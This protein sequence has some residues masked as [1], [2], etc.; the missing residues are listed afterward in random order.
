MVA[1]SLMKRP[2]DCVLSVY[3]NSETPVSSQCMS[4]TYVSHGAN[5]SYRDSGSGLPVIFLHPTPLDHAYWLPMIGELGEVRAI[6]PDLRGHGSSELGKDLPVG[7]F[8]RVPDAP[9]LSMGQ[10]AMDVLALMDHLALPEAV[11][12][13]CSIGGYVMTELWRR[14]P[15]RMRGLAI[16]CSKPQP[17]VESNFAKRAETIAQIRSAGTKGV[18][19]GNAQTLIGASARKQRPEIVAELRARM[20]LTAEAVIATQ[21]GLA[22]RP[23]SVPDIAG[24]DAPILAICGGEDPGI[25][26]AEMR[27]FEG[28]EG[29]CEFHLLADAGHFAAYEQPAKVAA[30]IAPWFGQFEF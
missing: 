30:L 11:F 21:A 12:A 9:V 18:F 27:A 16:V 1:F 23:D 14:A 19:D 15:L 10:L 5:L 13:G 8:Q 20:T 28:A 7:G 6:V 26:E 2:L 25:T 29:G 3:T 4:K 22:T 24:I 17:D